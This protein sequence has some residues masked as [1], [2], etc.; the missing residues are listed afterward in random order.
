MIIPST[1]DSAGIPANS[2]ARD[3]MGFRNQ[4]MLSSESPGVCRNRIQARTRPSSVSLCIRGNQALRSARPRLPA[5]VG[6][7]QAHSKIPDGSENAPGELPEKGTE[8]GRRTAASLRFEA[9]GRV[10]VVRRQVWDY[11]AVGT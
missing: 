3:R 1:S 10:Q 5:A 9:N 8:K 11:L 4:G 6:V 2:A 7:A